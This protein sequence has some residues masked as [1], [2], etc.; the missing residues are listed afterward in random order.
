MK[1]FEKQIFDLGLDPSLEDEIFSEN[2]DEELVIHAIRGNYAVG[3]VYFQVK[4]PDG[5]YL[6]GSKEIKIKLEEAK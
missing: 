1:T 2:R 5:R 6:K 3:A 4:L